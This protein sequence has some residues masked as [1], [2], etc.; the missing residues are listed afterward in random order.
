MGS[1]GPE[2]WMHMITVAQ[3]QT[4]GIAIQNRGL[5]LVGKAEEAKYQA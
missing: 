3:N 1:A 4:E 2:R 5:A